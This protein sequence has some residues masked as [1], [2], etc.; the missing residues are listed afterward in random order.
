[1]ESAYGASPTQDTVGAVRTFSP[2][3]HLLSLCGRIDGMLV[4][5]W[6]EAAPMHQQPHG[7][8]VWLALLGLILA[9]V[10]FAIVP[11]HREGVETKDPDAPGSKP[12]DWF[13]AQRAYP[14]SVIPMDRYRLALAQ[15]QSMRSEAM[16]AAGERGAVVWQPAGPTNIMGRITCVTA[17]PSVP[18]RIFLGAAA[19]GVFRTTDNG[20]TWACV[21]DDYGIAS[22]GDLATDPANANV[23]YAGTGEANA[24]GD[25]YNGIGLFRSTDGGDS[26]DFLGLRDTGHITRVAVDPSNSSRIWVAAMGNLFTKNPERGVYRSDDGGAS[27]SLKLFVSDSTGASDVAV[28]PANPN[29]VY[30]AM[31][32]RIRTAS[33]RRAGGITSGIFKSTD[34]G[35]T[36][37]RLAGGLP[38]QGPTVGRIGLGLAASQPSTVYAIYADD[39]GYFLGVFKTTDA[40]AH[41]AHAD[42]GLGGL[43]SNFGWYF[44]QIRV[45]PTDSN[46]AFALGVPFYRTTN[47]GTSWSDASSFMHVDHHA[48]WIDPSTPTR[49]IEGNDG[50]LYRST[51]GGTQWSPFTGLPITQFYA[52]TVDFQNPQRLYGGTQD[53]GTMRTLT[54]NLDDWGVFYGGDGMYCLVDPTNANVIFAEYQYGGL[55]KSTNGGGSFGDATN[56]INGGDRRNWSVPVVM[57]P[58]NS[59]VLYYGTYRVY[60]T[61]NGAA[62]WSAISGDLTGGQGSGNLQFPT[63]TTIAVAPSSPATVYAGTD[64]GHA[65][66]T[67]NTGS[68]WTNV[69]AGLPNR[70]VTRVAVDPQNRDIVYTTVSGYKWDEP[71]PHVFRSVNRG[72]NWSD[73]SSNL[74]DGPV[75][76]IVVDPLDS[77]TLYVATDFGVFVSR[78]LGGRW[79]VLG[80][81]LPLNPICDLCLHAPTRSLISGTHGRS[82]FRLSLPGPAG[83]ED[84]IAADASSR[85]T[86]ELAGPNP[87]RNH[88][89][90]TLRL[91]RSASVQLRIVDATGRTVRVV[92]EGTLPAG[93]R[94][95]SWNGRDAAGG[96]APAG[97][98]FARLDADGRTSVVRF[99]RAK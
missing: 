87:F 55:G 33:Y 76:S 10:F 80:A 46:K 36:W 86:I 40:G 45:D 15:A 25:S 5:T 2:R 29:T 81:G 12:N 34:G 51:N 17:H 88:A 6:G 47:G 43:Y 23:V 89:E 49:L 69:S 68:S 56:G 93:A 78:N 30:A 18:G 98:Y 64:D 67:T 71:Q 74:P 53:N 83:V 4:D 59:Q 79:D 28:D 39:P 7:R 37:G 42:A 48:L 85:P 35:E 94:R 63:V 96:E 73:I 14:G 66:V 1:M 65:W 3:I 54:G 72:T 21:T 52:I 16:A 20:A 95:I 91:P 90:F 82:M 97:I 75:N 27:W 99:V 60:R 70:W 57:D 77:N 11:I 61:S 22:M 92:N 31:W 9:G 44:G 13:Y 24:S 41:W 19:G 32:E 50:G 62:N 58:T 38:A 84:E 8:N 26:W